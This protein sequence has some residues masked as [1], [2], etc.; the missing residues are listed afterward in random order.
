MAAYRH[1]D[2]RDDLLVAMV[3]M[4]TRE[5][6]ADLS[7]DSGWDVTLRAVAQADWDSFAR[8]P[9]LIEVWSTPRRRVDMGSFDRLELLLDQLAAAGVPERQ[10]LSIVLGV[11]GMTLGM[12]A[13]AIED[14][15][16][17]SEPD[18]SEFWSESA[19]V[20]GP[21]FARTHP[22]STWFM[23]HL[24]DSGGHAAFAD[25]LDAFLRG[26]AARHGLHVSEQVSNS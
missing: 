15:G 13:M 11:L 8:H 19:R 24:D 12:A 9:W 26:V 10:G 16:A 22:R 4:I 1:V 20:M 17:A 7:A 6:R 25:A 21:D 3:D 18:L 23:T 2:D 5:R 14:A